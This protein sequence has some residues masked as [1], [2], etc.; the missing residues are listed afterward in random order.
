[1]MDLLVALLTVGV[2]TLLVIAAAAAVFWALGATLNGLMDL[3]E[4][5]RK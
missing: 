4:P 2:L 3:F 1:M 5:R